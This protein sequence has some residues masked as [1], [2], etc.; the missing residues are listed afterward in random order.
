VTT[1]QP[2]PG[3]APDP[4]SMPAPAAEPAPASPARPGRWIGPIRVTPVSVLITLVLIGS[5]VFIVYVT[6]KVH[7]GQIPLLAAGFV[8]FGAAWAAIA[9]AAL[10]A[11]W[12]AASYARTGRATALAIAGGVAGLGAIGCFAIAALLTLVWNT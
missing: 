11:M 7:D 9:V 2:A 3:P 12:R 1:I 4:G 8:A 5:L 6:F 10:V